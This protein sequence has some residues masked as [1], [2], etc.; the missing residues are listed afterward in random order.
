MSRIKL[1]S[2]GFPSQSQLDYCIPLMKQK[3]LNL[4][5]KFEHKLYT[6]QYIHDSIHIQEGRNYSNERIKD[7]IYGFTIFR[8]PHTFIQTDIMVREQIQFILQNH[9]QN[10]QHL[11]KK[12]LFIGG[13][14]Y[15]F[16]FFFKDCDCFV[17]TD[18]ESIYQDTMYN[19]ENSGAR[20]NP[21]LVSY[22]NFR[23]EQSFGIGIIN[24]SRDLSDSTWETIHV[25]DLIIIRCHHINP[26][27]N[28]NLFKSWICK[29]VTIDWYK[30]I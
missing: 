20:V 19:S 29:H 6:F 9:L 8:F 4:D 10:I 15:V 21:N 3:I 30:R 24:L 1:T 2:T 27:K 14:C 25:N 28:Y 23:L 16:P 12:M 22:S 18:F 13:E 17:Y 7:I 5:M 11:N 26:R